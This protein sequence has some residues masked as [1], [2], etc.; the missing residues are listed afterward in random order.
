MEFF[1]KQ[2]DFPKMYLVSLQTLQKRYPKE[3]HTH[4]L[5]LF[6]P[7]YRQGQGEQCERP[8]QGGAVASCTRGVARFCFFW[9][10]MF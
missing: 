9:Y 5:S 10:P 8:R 7:A 4:L 3:G 1:S 6:D 2:G